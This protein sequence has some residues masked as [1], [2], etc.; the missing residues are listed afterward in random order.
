MVEIQSTFIQRPW[1]LFEIGAQAH[2]EG[3]VGV[4]AAQ[5]GLISLV[6]S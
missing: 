4:L 6:R 1:H 3:T 2:R 5:G